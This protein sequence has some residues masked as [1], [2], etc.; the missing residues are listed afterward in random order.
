MSR[1]HLSVH[2]LFVCQNSA[3]VLMF[4][5]AMDLCSLEDIKMPTYT[6]EL[7]RPKVELPKDVRWPI[8]FDHPLITCYP[9]GALP[10][11]SPPPPQPLTHLSPLSDSYKPEKRRGI[12]DRYRKK[13]SRRNFDKRAIYPDRS[14]Y[15]ST[16]PRKHGRFI[17]FAE[18]RAAE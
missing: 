6:L 9:I 1:V 18:M 16:R 11:S 7:T 14:E 5:L 8:D 10:M 12:I 2:C 4:V 3:A 13:R 17:S 15:A